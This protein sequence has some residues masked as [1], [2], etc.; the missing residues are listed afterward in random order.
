[1]SSVPVPEPN[2]TKAAVYVSWAT[3][4]NSL[5]EL[6]QGVPNQ[7]D[8]TAFP[9][10]AWGVQS[11]LLAGLKFLGLIDEKLKPLPL[12][13]DLAVPDEAVRKA[14]L[15]AILHERYAALFALDLTK[16]TPAQLDDQMTVSYNVKGATR[17][18]AVRFFLSAADY[19][20]TPMSSLLKP[21]R[22]AGNGTPVRRRRSQP[23]VRRAI[24]PAAA[25]TSGEPVGP[26]HG[27]KRTVKLK[28][29]GT[30]TLAVSVDLFTLT[31]DDRGF[32]FEFIDKLSKYEG[33]N[34][35]D[36]AP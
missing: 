35:E 15:G 21:S 28:S 4:K 9:G 13:H 32:V 6:A 3:F 8:R 29:G 2:G 12:L 5:E 24:P 10:M 19:V 17:E 11:Q 26:T 20:D 7:I 25:S 33:Q 16:T 14:K 18:K 34:Q 27:T 31:A 22:P 23:V 30:L 1:M 36:E